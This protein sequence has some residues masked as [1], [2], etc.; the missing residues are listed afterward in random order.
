MFAFQFQS[1][2]WYITHLKILALKWSPYLSYDLYNSLAAGILPTD[3]RRSLSWY[4]K[5]GVHRDSPQEKKLR[6]CRL[7][8]RTTYESNLCVVHLGL[9]SIKEIYIVSKSRNPNNSKYVQV[10]S[11]IISLLSADVTDKRGKIMGNLTIL[12][13]I[14]FQEDYRKRCINV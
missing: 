12:T 13:G 8:Q 2:R 7:K 14:F 10:S 6:R 1:S 3:P 9:F 4:S 11:D 5:H